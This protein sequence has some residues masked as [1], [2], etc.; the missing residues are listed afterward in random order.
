MIK[1]KRIPKRLTASEITSSLKSLSGWHYVP[2]EKSIS[3]NLKMKNF[4]SVIRAMQDIAKLAE[5]ANHHPGLHLT[6]YRHFKI[7]LS[8]HEAGGVTEKDFHLARQI[9]IKGTSVSSD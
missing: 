7:S 2:G 3:A 8:T 5:K 9:N 4:M 6:Q 1:V